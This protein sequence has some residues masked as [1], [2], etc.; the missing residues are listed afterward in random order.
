MSNVD[1]RGLINQPTGFDNQPESLLSGPE[2][3]AL[4]GVK[5]ETLYA[6]TSRGL[7]R[8]VPSDG[9]R[10]RLYVREDLERLKARSDARRGHGPVA[11]SALRW[12]EP[13]LTSTITTIGPEGP[14]YRGQA[15]TALAAA[16]A[17]FESVAELLWTGTL[18]RERPTWTVPEDAALPVTRLADLVPDGAPPV[19]TLALAVP[20][21]AARDPLR[22]AATEEA[23]LP[24]ARGLIRRL[25]ALSALP[26]GARR[27]KAA[28]AEPTVS[29]ALLV[30]LGGRKTERAEAAVERALVLIADHELATSTFAVRVTASTGADLYACVSAGLAAVSGP[31]H[32]GACDR[33]EAVVAEVGR[34]ERAR[35]V[36]AAR[37]RRGDAI[38][39][40]GHPFYP[41]GDPR[42]PPLLV[43]AARVG[44]PRKTDVAALFA[45]L[46]ATKEAGYPPPSVDVGLVALCLALGLPPGAATTFFAIGRLAGWIAHALEQRG[47]P[48][49]LRPRSVAS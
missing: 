22:F 47:D 40:L 7:V 43:D 30:A 29:R 46:D 10:S 2:A 11:A 14:R 23:E 18:P 27:A 15:A 26:A 34:P 38:L 4:L 17:P 9:G 36:V 1:Q 5:R 33:I 32:G 31:K 21:L 25:A 19:A 13:V 49:L 39:E 35:D 41:E 42:T 44:A 28:L 45:L 24:R 12:G 20:A 8:S 37:A 48:T 6:Y 3:A 16:G